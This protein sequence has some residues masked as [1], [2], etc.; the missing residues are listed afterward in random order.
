[1]KGTQEF[2][3][4][5]NVHQGYFKKLH[6][7]MHWAPQARMSPPERLADAINVRN[8]ISRQRRHKETLWSNWKVNIACTALGIALGALVTLFLRNFLINTP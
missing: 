2:L 7:C 1:M 3:F 5:C 6:V 4:Y 8:E